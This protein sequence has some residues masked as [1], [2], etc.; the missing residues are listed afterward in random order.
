MRNFRLVRTED[1]SGISGTGIIA[2]GVQFSSGKCVLAWT[3]E[4]QSVAVYD[5]IEELD[6]IHGHNGRTHI[7]WLTMARVMPAS[8]R[9]D[10]SY[11]EDD[12]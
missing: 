1:V 7:E 6:A 2:E 9:S 10:Y 5:S 8:L 11:D 12:T 3:T 4:Y